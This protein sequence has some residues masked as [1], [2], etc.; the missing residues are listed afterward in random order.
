MHLAAKKSFQLFPLYTAEP[1]CQAIQ[2][3]TEDGF[4]KNPLSPLHA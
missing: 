4:K 3:F 2:S 1:F